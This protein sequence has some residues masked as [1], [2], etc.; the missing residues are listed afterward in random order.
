MPVPKQTFE[1][2]WLKGNFL[3]PVDKSI[4]IELRQQLE[5][6]SHT[7]A[8]YFPE[9]KEL[10]QVLRARIAALDAHDAVLSGN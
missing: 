1:E 7:I 4:R 6:Y 9:N 3:I 2:T 8:M 5:T 10:K